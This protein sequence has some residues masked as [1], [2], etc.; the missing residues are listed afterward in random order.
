VYEGSVVV[1][2][3]IL[4]AD[5]EDLSVVEDLL[6]LKLGEETLDLGV[7]IISGSIGDVEVDPSYWQYEEETSGGSNV[8][9][10]GEEDESRGSEYVPE[11]HIKKTISENKNSQIAALIIII[12]ALVVT[13]VLLLAA[14]VILKNKFG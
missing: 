12:A 1:D 9:T 11:V 13:G 10:G 6:E 8:E 7:V 3:E 14:Y 2:Y 5:D 4:Q